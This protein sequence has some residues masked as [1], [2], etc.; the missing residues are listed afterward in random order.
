LR[1]RQAVLPEFVE[2]EKNAFAWRNIDTEFA[3]L[4]YDSDCDSVFA[5]SMSAGSASMLGA[6]DH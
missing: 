4:T 2:A 3:Q 5:P 6:T 1:A